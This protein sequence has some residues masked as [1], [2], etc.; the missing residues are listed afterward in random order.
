M[1]RG[2]G[3]GAEALRGDLDRIYVERLLDCIRGSSLH[4]AVILGQDEP[5]R[6]NGTRIR[7][8]ASFY[9][10]NE[11]VLGLG[12]KHPELLPGVSIH[13]ARPDA[14]DELERCLAA[15]AVLLKCL[16]NCQSID[17]SLRRYTPFL[18]RMAEAGLPLLAHTGGEH[19]LP[20]IDA[21][22]ADPRV[23]A[24]PLEIGVTCI[25]AHCGTNT[26]PFG[27]YFDVFAGL[28]R[29]HPRLYGDTSAF[30]ALGSFR[31]HR[32][33]RACVGPEMAGR[34]IHGSDS[35]VPV[36][37]LS[38]RLSGLISREALV[39]SRRI[40]NPLERDVFLKR[41]LGFSD[42][43]F[44]RASGLLRLPLPVR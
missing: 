36:N 34:L 2:F 20:V 32:A 28:L 38:L 22:L 4:A 44:T 29:R 23:L 8:V 43:T 26:L 25:A 42:D 27:D 13:P 30:C 18:E 39:A 33:I 41:A 31:A 35:P 21:R 11:Y 14:L 12:Q 1:L 37:G 15:G 5:Y 16:P 17:W 3:L 19:T 9:V 40:G 6:E 10:P 24:R 7:D